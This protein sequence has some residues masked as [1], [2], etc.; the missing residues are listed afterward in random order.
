MRILA[1]E[2]S[3]KAGSVALLEDGRLLA[4]SYC[5]T[6]LTH[7]QTLL[8]MA[9]ELLKTA[10]M[11]AKDVEAVAVAAGPGSFTGVRIGVAAAKGFSWG[12]ELPCY[13]VSTLEAMA[14]NLGVWSG[15]V[16]PV[17]DARRS[18]VY[19]ALFH[20]DGG[21][22]TRI[23]ADRAI[24][25]QE[26]GEELKKLPE[27]IFLVGDGSILC[28]NT[29]AEGVSGLVLPPEHRMHQRAAGVALAAWE[30]ICS[31]V[32]GDGK[33]LCPNYLRVSQAERERLA[34]EQK[35]KGE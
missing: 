10:G 14:R 11:T 7:S 22:L 21:K 27:P 16:C 20:T 19:N 6:G 35:D 24:S 34:R 23:A 9:Q 1:F 17:M 30:Q 33:A 18:Q 4:E 15:Y 32:S 3:A 2:T 29:L 31:G 13:G 5:N 8:T 12:A 26:L 28:Y 25:L